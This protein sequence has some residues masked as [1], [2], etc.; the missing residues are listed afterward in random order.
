M[1]D[2]ATGCATSCDATDSKPTAAGWVPAPT[3]AASASARAASVMGGS[4]L[5]G[6][7]PTNPMLTSSVT[8]ST[9][10]EEAVAEGVPVFV[11]LREPV[12]V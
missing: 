4:W 3:N 7:A 1:D 8:G 2:D 11:A 9:L 10:L 12:G 5:P 6:H